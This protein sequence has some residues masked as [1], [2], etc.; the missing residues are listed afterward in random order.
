MK[1]RFLCLI[2]PP[3]SCLNRKKLGKTTSENANALKAANPDIP[4]TLSDYLAELF[5]NL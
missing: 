5:S 2:C 4:L 1:V 3:H